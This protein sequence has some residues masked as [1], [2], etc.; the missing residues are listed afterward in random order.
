MGRQAACETDMW[1]RADLA[2]RGARSAGPMLGRATHPP[3]DPGTTRDSDPGA[4]ELKRIETP[5]LA[6]LQRPARTP[7]DQAAQAAA[8]RQA[9]LTKPPGSLGRL[10]QVAIRLAGMQGREKP[11]LERVRVTVFAADHGVAAEGVSAFPQA[12]T[13]EM[14]RNFARGGAAISVLARDL[15]AV[16][17]VVDLGTVTPPGDLPGVI[18]SRIAAGTANLATGPAMTPAQL[19]AALAAGEQSARRA[20]EAGCDLFVGGEMGIANTTAASALACALLGETA[21][22]MTGPGTGLDATGIDHKRQVIERALALHGCAARNPM[23][24]LRRLGGFEI[25]ALTGSFIACAQTGIPVLVD[26]FICSVA[27]LAATRLRPGAEHWLLFAHRSAEPGHQRVLAAM[28][29]EPLLDLGMR[30][31][32]ASGAAVAVPLLRAA[33]ALHARMA[34]FTEAGVSEA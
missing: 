31:G 34:T 5:D 17:E 14:L 23:E 21:A 9:T 25:A 11:D 33:C 16:F 7:D 20:T 13:T 27:A 6:W 19:A 2:G 8:T 18:D 10:E 26:G 24:A 28:Q 15:G 29:A 32:E 1:C 22:L 30:L 12:V 3:A 4:D